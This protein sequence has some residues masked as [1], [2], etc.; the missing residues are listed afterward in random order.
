MLQQTKSQEH[1]QQ[2][3]R[4]QIDHVKE[5]IEN[6]H[7]QKHAKSKRNRYDIQRH[8]Q[9]K[10]R[11]DKANKEM[12]DM[13]LKNGNTEEGLLSA[14]ELENSEDNLGHEIRK[15]L[16]LDSMNAPN[17]IVG[18]ETKKLQ[19]AQL[20]LAAKSMLYERNASL[21]DHFS[22]VINANTDWNK[23]FKGEE[24]D[25]M[26][27]SHTSREQGRKQNGSYHTPTKHHDET[28]RV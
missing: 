17:P 23:T 7:I 5:L 22:S 1:I 28:I 20:S 14:F 18:S 24:N 15:K 4:V 16:A 10:S 12:R 21:R 2:S 3:D 9:C 6:V 8:D 13:L 19:Q 11:N 27:V 25:F 26:V